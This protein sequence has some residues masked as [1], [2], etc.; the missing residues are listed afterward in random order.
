MESLGARI[1]F[2]RKAAGKTQQAVADLFKI[3]RVNVTQWE[4]MT[5]SPGRDRI[6]PLAD[7]L[8]T[9]AEWLLDETGPGPA[10]PK[11]GASRRPGQSITML[12][13]P[14]LVG[15]RNLPVYAA[16]MGG[17]G[18]LIVTFDA[19]DYVKR[20]IDL[21]A[22]RD[23]YGILIVGTSMLPKYREGDIALVHP[24]LPPAQ[25]R[26]VVLYHEEPATGEAEAIVKT[27][28]SWTDTKWRLRQYNP[29][30]DFT[31]SRTDWRHCHRVVGS[32]DRR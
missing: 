21:E 22:V 30:Q 20:P 26:E 18:H 14:A 2:A 11:A 27:L 16:A 7:F 32:Y 1:K 19:V 5:T 8:G 28:L 13:R 29:P 10:A 24:H 3:K 6:K 17:S 31:E 15:D 9:T 25:E 12:S 23:G 4:S